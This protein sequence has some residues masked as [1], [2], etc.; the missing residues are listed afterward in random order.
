MAYEEKGHL[1]PKAHSLTLEERQK[2]SVSGVEEVVSFDEAQVAVQT[3]KGLLTIRGSGLRVEAL[4]KE[5][6][7]LTIAGTVTDLSY[8]ETGPGTGFWARIF[9]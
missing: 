5:A 4:E 6:G 3:V 2:L 7:L 8:E 9:R 1:P